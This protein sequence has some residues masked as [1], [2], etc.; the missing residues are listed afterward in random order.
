MTRLHR[1]AVPVSAAMR[2]VNHSS[3]AV[4]RIYWR[5]NV[6]D[7]RP[8][9]DVSLFRNSGQPAPNSEDELPVEASLKTEMLLHAANFC[10]TAS[11]IIRTAQARRLSAS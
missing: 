1:A 4:H 3:E 6:E 9:A 7:V 8:Y 11:K 10:I 5:L 2:L